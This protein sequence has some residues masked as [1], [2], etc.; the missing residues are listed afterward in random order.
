MDTNKKPN[1]MFLATLS[2]P[3]AKIY[4]FL[5]NDVTPETTQ[6][7]DKE[8]YKNKDIIKSRFTTADGK[9]DEIAF[10]NAYNVALYNFNA[11]ADEEGIKKLNEVEYD[12]FSFTR[13]KDS[14]TFNTDV[15]FSTDY[16]PFKQLYSRDS[17]NSISDSSLS[18]REI[19]QKGRIHDLGNNTWS[20][21]INEEGLFTKVLGDTLVYAQWDNDGVHTDP[22]SGN[23]V[24]HKKGDWKVDDTG[25]LYLEKLGNR[26]LYGKQIVNPMDILTTDGSIF[27]KFDFLDSDGREK[28]VGKVATK[29]IVE[30]A[31]LLIPGVNT[32]YGGTRAAI[33]LASVMPTFYKSL[34]SLLLGDNK[35]VL[36]DPV[37]KAE[38]WM[39]K[40]N[41]TSSSDK[42]AEGFWNFEQMSS[43]VTDIFSQIYEQRAMAGLSKILMRPDKLLDE[44]VAA[45]KLKTL[46]KA[47]PSAK[48]HNIDVVKAIQDVVENTPEIKAAFAKQSQLS[49]ALSL[50]YMAMTSTGDIYGE[51]V[52]SG[53]DRR[54][55][56]FASLLAASGQY[57]IMMNNKMGDWFLDKTTGYDVN[58]N[59]S[60]IKKSIKPYLQKISD[61]L[62]SPESVA[63]KR[64]KLAQ[65]SIN[66]KKSMSNFFSESS[67]IGEAMWKNAVVE[68]VEEVTEQVVQDASK[69]IVDVM[70]YLGLTKSRGSFRTIE[71]YA[72]G[73]AFQE[74]LANFVGGVLGGGLFELERSKISPWFQNKGQITPEIRK[75]VYEL[76]AN[77]HKAELIKEIKKQSKYLANNY[78]SYVD[79]NGNY[80]AKESGDSHA[81]LVSQKAI[82]MVEYL[83]VT[84]NSEGL[85][86]TDDEIINKAIR[87]QVFLSE[88]QK[89]LEEGKYIGLEG[90]ILDDFKNNAVK[91]SEIK[92]RINELKKNEEKNAEQIKVEQE[93]L[94][95]YIAKR[96]L[97]LS[98]DYGSEY[99]DRLA[100]ALNP[101]IKELFGSLDRQTY[102]K[103][104]YKVDFKD[105]PETGS[106]LNKQ[107]VDKEWQDFLDSTD[108]KAK[109]EYISN[110]YKEL[111]KLLNIPIKNYVTSGYDI[112]R[113]NIYDNIIDLRRTITQ[114]NTATDPSIK[115]SILNNFITINN[116]LESLGLSKVTPKDIYNIN[117]FDSILDLGLVKKYS[118]DPNTGEEIVEDYTQTELNT[119]QPN[120]KT[121]LENIKEDFNN[122]SKY[123]PSNALNMEEVINS[124]NTFIIGHNQEVSNKLTK[125]RST[126]STDPD[127]LSEIDSIEK[128]YKNVRIAPYTSAKHIVEESKKVQD[129]IN[130]KIGNAVS[131]KI[132]N[133]YEVYLHAEENKS[134]Y[135][136]SFSQLEKEI[137]GRK[138][139]LASFTNQEVSKFID[140]LN[141]LGIWNLAKDYFRG[142]ES[143]EIIKRAE[144]GE[145]DKEALTEVFNYLSEEVNSK[146]TILNDVDL[147]EARKYELEQKAELDKYIQDN[148]PEAFKLRNVAFDYLLE[149]I[150]KDG[151]NDKELYYE[152]KDMFIE[153]LEPFIKAVLPGFESISYEEM[154]YIINNKD[155]VYKEM[156]SF[157]VEY[158]EVIGEGPLGDLKNHSIL[159]DKPFLRELLFNNFNDNKQV[160]EIIDIL[161][162]FDETYDNL[163]ESQDI[164]NKFLDYE[165]KK[166]SLKGNALYD[167]IRN[168]SLTLNTNPD[169]KINKIFDILQNE[170][171]LFRASSGASNFIAD[172][173][174]EADLQQA[175]NTLDMIIAVIHAM[176]TT[177]YYGDE[178]NGFIAMRQKYARDS[179]I[180][181]EV[182]DLFTID[183]D[184]AAVMAGDIVKLKV[185]L[186]FIKDLAITN[187]V[188]SIAEHETIRANMTVSNISIFEHLANNIKLQPFIPKDFETIFTSTKEPEAKL[189][190]LEES[191]YLHNLGNE[192]AALEALLKYEF[193]ELNKQR[194]DVSMRN[195]ITKDTKR[196]EITPY[197][198][199]TYLATIL[200]TSSKDFQKM[201]LDTLTRLDKAPFYMQELSARMIKAS[202]QN[203]DLFAKIFELKINEDNDMAEY[204]TILLGGAGTGKTTAVSAIVLDL[205]RQTNESS[206]V[207]LSAPNQSQA[208]KFNSDVINSIG[209]E[210]ISFSALNKQKLFESFGK[211][212]GKLWSEIDV[213]QRDI[214][215]NTGKDKLFK[216]EN[217]LDSSGVSRGQALTFDLPS[218]W[219]EGIDFNN[220][221]HLLLIDEITHFSQAEIV[222]L[223][224]ISR[225]SKNLG[226]FMKVVGL[227]DQNQ[228][229]FQIEL[230][231][232]K[233]YSYLNYNINSL[234]AVFTPTLMTT[235]RATN[236][237]KRINNDFLLNLVDKSAEIFQKYNRDESLGSQEITRKANTELHA[238]YLDNVKQN[239]GLK[240]YLKNDEFRGDFIQTK[241][242]DISVLTAIK[243]SI[244]ASKETGKPETLNILTR[245][246][247]LDP[248]LAHALD[249][250]NLTPEYYTIY[251]TANIQG[252]ESDY[253]IFNADLIKEYDKDRDFLK[254]LYTYISR[255]K[256]G[257]VIMDFNNKLEKVNLSNAEKSKY[258]IP[259]DPLT[260]AAVE[261]IK[262]NRIDKIKSLIGDHTISK[263]SD[264]KWGFNPKKTDGDSEDG[265][266][267]ESLYEFI[268]RIYSASEKKTN[269]TVEDF[270][271][272]MHSFYNNLNVSIV[273]GGLKVD[274]NNPPTDL[275]GINNLDSAQ[276]KQVIQSWAK[277]KNNLFYNI[278]KNTVSVSE[279]EDFFRHIFPIGTNVSDSV[280]V[281][282]KLTLSKYNSET[283]QPFAK[284]GQKRDQQL[285]S[286]EPFINLSAKLTYNDKVHYITLAT[287]S[288][289]D[290]IIKAIANIDVERL[291][292]KVKAKESKAKLIV[293]INDV[294]TNIKNRLKTLE[295]NSIEDLVDVDKND[296]EFL[297]SIRILQTETDG[298]KDSFNL[299]QLKNKFLGLNVSEI[300]LYPG[301]FEKFKELYKRYTFGEVRT[302]EEYRELYS[303]LKNKSYV[304]VSFNNDLNGTTGNR[305]FAKMIPLLSEARDV[306]KLM[307]EATTLYKNHT[308]QLSEFYKDKDNEGKPFVFDPLIDAKMQMLIGRSEIIDILMQWGT[309][310]N[311]AGES[312]LSLLT[313]NIEGEEL[314][315]PIEL[316]NYFLSDSETTNKL[317][318]VIDI[319]KTELSK[320]KSREETKKNIIS[321]IEGISGWN[322]NFHNIFAYKK[323]LEDASFRKTLKYS[324]K[325]YSEI[326]TTIDSLI[327]TLKDMKIHYNIPIE[328]TADG[329]IVKPII[330][331]EGGFKS[332][333][334]HNKFRIDATLEQERT[335]F[336][337]D[338]FLSIPKGNKSSKGTEIEPIIEF[339]SVFNGDNFITGNFTTG[340]FKINTQTG[341]LSLNINSIEELFK[342]NHKFGVSVL[343]EGDI[344][345]ATDFTIVSN[346][347]VVKKNGVWVLEKPIILQYVSNQPGQDLSILDIEVIVPKADGSVLS[348]KPLQEFK[349][350]IDILEEYNDPNVDI[351]ELKTIISQVKIDSN[352][353]LGTVN[354][355]LELFAGRTETGFQSVKILK[356]LLPNTDNKSLKR[357]VNNVIKEILN[358]LNQCK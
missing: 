240:Y 294:F 27:N 272:M 305:T 71:R 90:L 163:I 215:N 311:N 343:G 168:F 91:I 151:Y 120:G 289:Q 89:N 336:S 332:E 303:R 246:G 201:Y 172:N 223:N 6:L 226:K 131:G 217:V 308:Y 244:D 66:I 37:T 278:G 177:S 262:S 5:N 187:A 130:Q 351:N 126:N 179:K 195:N 181:S 47:L 137:N 83:D 127:I 327:D 170:E 94:K 132:K 309:V 118:V 12:P 50:G 33:S 135:S 261:T 108:M 65:L 86:L 239:I 222:L 190:E 238:E 56:G 116:N 64:D 148:K 8:E 101:E 99:F 106:G 19:A 253:F 216:F 209:K 87:T 205:L 35:S 243:S 84:F 160:S 282:Y 30:I 57:G 208:D 258:Y 314:V 11:I 22:V 346:G 16:N 206:K 324:E 266:D 34:E 96:D 62:Q 111:E 248:D 224:A 342:V 59:R 315:S 152:L 155:E 357:E 352:D 114:F 183:S 218:N 280:K 225:K 197:T 20:K 219:D 350:I 129:S 46:E 234:N 276:S 307:Q 13:P 75:E 325:Q 117:S 164:I 220:L 199:V 178:S 267:N 338:K 103:T 298:K 214:E 40:F 265:D 92:D 304:V 169:N 48:K 1:D 210:L 334:F 112:V 102:V 122:Y 184:Q 269:T 211:G 29:T 97:I 256:I 69:A 10:D 286:A 68:G 36:T 281:E 202:I 145:I 330:N 285:S 171:M 144:S 175:I 326:K 188:K 141:Q 88:Y 228:M 296:V 347:K 107:Q 143:E 323:I 354:R 105:L 31:P 198:K 288:K 254:A 221:P 80:K 321:S 245:N 52:N 77:G 21:S 158:D 349:I 270:K 149:A 212:V 193:T 49:K 15:K 299:T 200:T 2:N 293:K 257:S 159:E 263:N 333:H 82:E 38:S 189:L 81:D 3:A 14:K 125:L 78:L 318:R 319:V 162:E 329:Y 204:I 185:K 70:G 196:E 58:V 302:D 260:K 32:W 317:A 72:T 161:Y 156:V 242:E 287:F 165:S 157:A 85:N 344:N 140:L 95:P 139:G 194:V 54:T 213:A 235:I 142:K 229:G 247:K 147:Q 138:K 51:A 4:D 232:G 100:I 358:K 251:T 60:L 109:L 41:Q 123:F 192:K 191:F 43:M 124:F 310:K 115:Q 133:A 236:D 136:K 76:V 264:F 259:Y 345:N 44:K 186:Q 25:S 67:V 283:N 353:A 356:G 39:A 173:I 301:N 290:T 154:S 339:S 337:L 250:A 63:I 284:F 7:L 252:S 174:R 73:E 28:S 18:L 268:E 166:K 61:I 237:Q 300:R 231:E 340:I 341:E 279:Y 322:F 128:S 233:K 17:V 227:G 277:L 110:A 335:L 23:L 79:E 45:L 113:K 26:E 328:N 182:L 42:G 9:F 313:K 121:L 320:N 55:A 249:L 292:D 176:S 150:Q 273:N 167:F 98:G 119:I 275:N 74:Y 297:T 93:N 348:V 255:S 295:S 146:N 316:L 230:K 241:K 203:P 180:K 153:E 274:Q 306:N 291:D 207:W 24:N 355:V 104:K 53:Y 312:L 271:P 134:L 331:G